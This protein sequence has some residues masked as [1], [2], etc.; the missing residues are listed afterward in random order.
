MTDGKHVM[1]IKGAAASHYS[2]Y[3]RRRQI[4]ALASLVDRGRRRHRVQVPVLIEC[5]RVNFAAGAEH[6]LLENALRKESMIENKPRSLIDTDPSIP[7]SRLLVR[8]QERRNLR[9]V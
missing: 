5:L 9:G 8:Y 3:S 6:G 1:R 7:L 2:P 4:F